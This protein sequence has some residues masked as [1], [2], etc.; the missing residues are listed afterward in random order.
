MYSGKDYSH[1]CISKAI[2]IGNEKEQR[3]FLRSEAIKT[4]EQIPLVMRLS[5]FL[6]TTLKL[7]YA[8]P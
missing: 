5:I 6:S 1:L 7:L 3:I 2:Y 8:I 4:N